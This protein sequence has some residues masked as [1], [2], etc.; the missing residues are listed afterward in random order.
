MAEASAFNLEDGQQAERK[1]LVTY[2]NTGTT[3]AP[4]WEKLGAM[5]EESAIEYNPDIDDQCFDF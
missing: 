4:V 5:V 1:L 2:V 3:I